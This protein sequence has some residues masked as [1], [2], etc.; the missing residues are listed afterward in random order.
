MAK[1]STPLASSLYC[2]CQL[3][4]LV[5][6]PVDKWP[7]LLWIIRHQAE[8][9]LISSAPASESKPNLSSRTRDPD[10]YALTWPEREQV[11]TPPPTHHHHPGMGGGGSVSPGFI[12]LVRG[13]DW[14]LLYDAQS[15][16]C[17]MEYEQAH[18]KGPLPLICNYIVLLFEQTKILSSAINNGIE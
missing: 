13:H 2:Q 1:Y 18:G 17:T 15:I 10:Y 4:I 14:I 3:A 8:T 5:Q 12:V 7:H 6:S 9:S 11:W 16:Y